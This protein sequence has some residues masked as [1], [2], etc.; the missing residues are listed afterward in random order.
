MRKS[1]RNHTKSV[2]EIRIKHVKSCEKRTE[3][4]IENMQKIA[5]KSHFFGV[6]YAKN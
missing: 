5:K 4:S 6:V 2:Q 1:V 3:N